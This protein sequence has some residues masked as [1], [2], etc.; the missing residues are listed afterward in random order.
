[1]K[2]LEKAVRLSQDRSV[3]ARELKE[4]G[5]KV[6]GYICLF[7]PVEL[8]SAAGLVPFRIIGS[9]EARGETDAYLERLM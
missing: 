7:P 1:M 9:F 5:R 3:R 6:M 2:A 4:E 8:I